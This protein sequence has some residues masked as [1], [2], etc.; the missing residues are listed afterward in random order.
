MT[1]SIFGFPPT[2]DKYQLD[3]DAVLY[4]TR[5]LADQPLF[6]DLVQQLSLLVRLDEQ[7]WKIAYGFAVRRSMAQEAAAYDAKWDDFDNNR[8][9]HLVKGF[10]KALNDMWIYIAGDVLDTAGRNVFVQVWEEDC[11]YQCEIRFD[12]RFSISDFHRVGFDQF[13]WL[14][15][16]EWHSNIFHLL[17]EQ[18]ADACIKEGYV[19]DRAEDSD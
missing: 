17:A 14:G 7:A 3:T 6:A 2:P 19:D 11:E 5:K 1:D 8:R 13:G 4:A 9:D 15:D 12:D 10:K 18:L 16:G